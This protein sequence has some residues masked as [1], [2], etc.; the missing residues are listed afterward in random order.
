VPG[1]V[2]AVHLEAPAAAAELLVQAEVVEH[3]PDVQQFRV[4]T[5]IPVSALQAAEPE[6]RREWWKTRSLVDSR[7]SS[8][9]SRASF[10]SGT[11]TRPL[12]VRW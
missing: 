9:A 7:T 4:E 3:R 11:G 6:D 12:S 5:E 1:F 8:V 2:G 10:V